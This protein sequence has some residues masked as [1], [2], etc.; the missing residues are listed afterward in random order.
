VGYSGGT[1]PN[2][3]YTDLGDHTETLQLDFDPATTDYAALLQVFWAAHDP[4]EKCGST[5]YMP[6]I[7]YHDES[8]KKLAEQTRAAEAARR[9]ET[10]HTE[11]RPAS[12]FTLAEDYHQK[13]FLRSDALLYKEIAHHY[14]KTADLI[15]STAAARL[16]GYVGGYGN[17]AGLKAEIDSLGLTAA[18]RSRLLALVKK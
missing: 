8:Q 7:F 3:S 11:I 1:K 4:T 15:R 14:P 13:Y 6:V 18:G 17:L 16:N 12:A 5:Q 9:G 10:I 2:P